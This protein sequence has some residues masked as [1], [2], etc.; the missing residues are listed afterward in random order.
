MEIENLA[1][2]LFGGPVSTEDETGTREDENENE[3]ENE[4]EEENENEIDCE[5]PQEREIIK[6]R[7][8]NE[9]KREK[10]RTVDKYFSRMK[11]ETTEQ[12]KVKKNSTS[13]KIK[14][15]KMRALLQQQQ[16]ELQTP[17]TKRKFTNTTPELAGR[18]KIEEEAT[19]PKTQ[20]QSQKQKSSVNV[21]DLFDM[22]KFEVCRNS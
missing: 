14:I 17:P 22:L 19:P 7:N 8:K 4:N 5:S 13:S 21:N 6:L 12:A 1:S 3:N 10:Q 15:Q 2:D 9:A 20:L 11:A 16:K 18:T